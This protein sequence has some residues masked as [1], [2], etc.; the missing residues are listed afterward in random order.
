MA[1][2]IEVRNH[3]ANVAQVM[4]SRK[5][6]QAEVEKIRASYQERIDKLTAAMNAKIAALGGNP[7][8]IAKWNAALAAIDAALDGT[9]ATFK[10]GQVV[11][12]YPEGAEDKV[13]TALAKLAMDHNTVMAYDPSPRRGHGGSSATSN[14]N[15]NAKS[16]L[17]NQIFCTK[18]TRDGAVNEKTIARATAKLDKLNEFAESEFEN[19]ADTI[20]AWKAELAKIA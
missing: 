16:W 10:G 12:V 19:N 18:R 4:A 1:S 15:T 9:T 20:R 5:A 7:D 8:Q 6:D 2:L 17:K 3:V 13:D 14:Y 11:E